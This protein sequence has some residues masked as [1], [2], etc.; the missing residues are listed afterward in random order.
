M[1]NDL[2][3]VVSGKVLFD[4]LKVKR[5]DSHLVEVVSSKASADD[6]AKEGAALLLAQTILGAARYAR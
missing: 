3:E 4:S 2:V 1:E 5:D 6:S